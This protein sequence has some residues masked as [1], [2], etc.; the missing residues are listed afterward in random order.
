MQDTLDINEIRMSLT[1]LVK[2]FIEETTSCNRKVIYMFNSFIC[3]HL[4]VN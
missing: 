1:D 2:R 4:F 3:I